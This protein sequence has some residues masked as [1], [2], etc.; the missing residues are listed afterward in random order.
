MTSASGRS[1]PAWKH[2]LDTRGRSTKW[3]ISAVSVRVE[4]ARQ[5]LLTT[6]LP[7][8]KIAPLIGFMDRRA[9]MVFFKRECGMTPGAFRDTHKQ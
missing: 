3:Q 2:A 8:T 7:L 6:E 5:Y 4:K 1:G 9:F